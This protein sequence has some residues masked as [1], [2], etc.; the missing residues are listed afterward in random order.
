MS[1][2][3]ATTPPLTVQELLDIFG[4][5]PSKDAFRAAI[6]RRLH[7]LDPQQ[8]DTFVAEWRAATR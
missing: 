3:T 4:Q 6:T 7:E 1:N 5:A 2:V 8:L